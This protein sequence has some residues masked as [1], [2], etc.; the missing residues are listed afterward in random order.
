MI[1]RTFE[2]EGLDWRFVS[3]E[4]A[5]ERLAEALRG[6]DA[7]G[8]RGVKL[9][10]PY[11]QAA[12]AMAAEGSLGPI[13][14]SERA[15][16]TGFVT[17]FSRPSLDAPL[18]GDDLSGPA[19]VETLAPL[20]PL[21]G[22]RVALLGASGPAASLAVSLVESGVAE[23]LVA[24]PDNEAATQF[25]ERITAGA[26]GETAVSPIDWQGAWLELPDGLDMVVASACWPRHE[27]G[28]VAKAVAAE[29]NERMVVADLRVGSSR[30]PLLR[31]AAERGATGVEGL[32]VLVRESAL[33]LQAWTGQPINPTVL[34]EAAEEFLGV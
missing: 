22:K 1:Q 27:D 5:P 33:S 28:R 15:A 8:F 26:A 12:A 10:D 29:L 6:A 30:S 20:G 23:L 7:L 4:V 18:S 11:R 13:G 16:Q 17:G 24:D 3:F 2:A 31:A 32:Q 34:S 9:L 14:L 21:R 19:L 25:V